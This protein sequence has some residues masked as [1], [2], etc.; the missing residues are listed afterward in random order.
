MIAFKMGGGRSGCK[1]WAL[2]EGEGAGGV[3]AADDAAISAV[4][5]YDEL[6]PGYDPYTVHYW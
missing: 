3:F 4:P 1:L 6:V 2:L 5:L